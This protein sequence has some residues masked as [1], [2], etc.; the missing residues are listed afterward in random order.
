MI[1]RWLCIAIMILSS[2]SVYA[3]DTTIKLSEDPWPPYTYGEIGQKPTG[4]IAVE[5]T[6][7]IFKRIGI[8][9]ELIL[10]PWKR[11]LFQAKQGEVDGLMLLEKTEERE[12]YLVFTA[13]LF[14]FEELLW[15]SKSRKPIEWNEF[16]DLKDYTFGRPLGF[17]YGED[18]E[19][20][21]KL[22][23]IHII[24]ARSD[25]NLFRMLALGRIDVYIASEKIAKALFSMHP[26]LQGKFAYSAKPITSG[27]L[28]MALSKKSSF[29]DRLPEINM[30]IKD[31]INDGT[32]KKIVGHN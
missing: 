21:V 11:C 10:C 29:L 20:A 19:S 16:R 32:M 23:G 3:D 24:K 30:T 4:G 13:P 12:A 15:F 8:K 6:Q 1:N 7:E 25:L 5:V 22:L 9:T 31:M 2:S 27:H 17:Q 14:H 18:F 28:Y 26:D